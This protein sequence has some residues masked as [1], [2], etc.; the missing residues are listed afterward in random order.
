MITNS[1]FGWNGKG[2]RVH[3]SCLC[4]IHLVASSSMTSILA[5]IFFVAVLT[6]L[7]YIPSLV[8]HFL[9]MLPELLFSFFLFALW[10][11]VVYRFYKLLNDLTNTLWKKV[12]ESVQGGPI[13]EWDDDEIRRW[14]STA[15]NYPV[16]ENDI[17]KGMIVVCPTYITLDGIASA[18]WVR[19]HPTEGDAFFSPPTQ[20]ARRWYAVHRRY[21]E[22]TRLRV[23]LD[24]PLLYG[25]VEEEE[26]FFP[27]HSEPPSTTHLNVVKKLLPANVPD[28]SS[29]RF[30]H[31]RAVGPPFKS[32]RKKT[33]TPTSIPDRN[34][35]GQTPRDI[36]WP[37]SS[38]LDEG[39]VMLM[40][41]PPSSSTAT[42]GDDHADRPALADDHQNPAQLQYDNRCELKPS[43]SHDRNELHARLGN[44]EPPST[45]EYKR[46][47]AQTA[48]LPPQETADARTRIGDDKP[49]VS[50]APLSPSPA[51]SSSTYLLDLFNDEHDLY[52]DDDPRSD[53]SSDSMSICSSIETDT[54]LNS[55]LDTNSITFDIEGTATG[56]ADA[57][58]QPLFIVP[59]DVEMPDHQE[60]DI[61]L[62]L[63]GLTIHD[64]SMEVD[65]ALE[66]FGI[67]SGLASSSAANS[68]LMDLDPVG[69][70]DIE[71]ETATVDSTHNGMFISASGRP[72]RPFKSRLR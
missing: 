29:K 61:L 35:N 24:N 4:S 33:P 46:L 45:Q 56:I 14:S 23:R 26:K 6:F 20:S 30:A 12:R 13:Y 2:E 18:V 62:S 36:D 44:I 17:T 63:S 25:D 42:I 55:T 48:S 65:S 38:L 34:I 60:A 43:K 52:C 27:G 54:A 51:M 19:R 50:M 8:I 32:F 28:K 67:P 53:E 70:S 49:A 16:D 5:P 58:P 10:I 40:K 41:A 47:Q 37:S 59:E 72:I 1:S 69:I 22:S 15:W 9:N 31:V 71:M 3:D 64:Q 68:M 11:F 66:S 21:N 7:R 57:Y 39:P